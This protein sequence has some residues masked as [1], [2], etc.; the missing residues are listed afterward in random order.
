MT[1]LALFDDIWLALPDAVDSDEPLLLLSR[2]NLPAPPQSIHTDQLCLLKYLHFYNDFPID[3]VSFEAD[4]PTLGK[5]GLLIFS[6][7]FHRPQHRITIELTH[8]RSAINQLIINPLWGQIMQH[9]PGLHLAA[10]HFNYYPAPVS[11]H[12]WSSYNLQPYELPILYLTNQN[13][14]LATAQDLESRNVAIGFG[15]LES[16]CRFAELLLNC[17]RPSN[18]QLEFALEG[19]IGYRGVGP[20]SAEI[21]IWLPGSIGNL[22]CPPEFS[23]S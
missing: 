6:A 4:K 10:T 8:P 12:P 2:H 14:M 11:R 13:E 9:M 19:E 1:D 21:V 15:G 3:S 22:D 18:N 20:G 16:S 17:S 23:T 7:I 5:L